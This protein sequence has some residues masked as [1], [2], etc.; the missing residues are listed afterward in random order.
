MADDRLAPAPYSG[1]VIA[2]SPGRCFR[3]VADDDRGGYP[4]RC[5]SSVAWKGVVV[6]P[7]GRRIG[8]EACDGHAPGLVEASAVSLGRGFVGW[9][10]VRTR[11]P[12]R[13]P[14]GEKP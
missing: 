7:A 13:P 10:S 11:G 5:P 9:P 6:D 4:V 1:N 12:G 3:Y 8:V 14:D 2:P